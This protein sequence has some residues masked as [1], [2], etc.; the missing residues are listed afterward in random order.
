MVIL[1]NNIYDTRQSIKD[2]DAGAGTAR[3]YQ[4]GNGL[5]TDGSAALLLTDFSTNGEAGYVNGDD[6]YGI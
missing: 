4:N 1:L 5:T 6:L 2:Y 3:F